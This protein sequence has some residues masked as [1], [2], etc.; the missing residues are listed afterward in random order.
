MSIQNYLN[1]IKSAVFGKDVRQ[2]I[3]DAIKQCYDDASIDHDNANMEVKLARGSHDT[4]NERFTSVEENI[5][6]NSEQL[7]KNVYEMQTNRNSI[8]QLSTKVDSVVSGSPKGVYDTVEALK[9]SFPTGSQGIYLVNNDG[10]WYYWNENDWI[11][12]G[13]YQSTEIADKSI[14][15][16]KLIYNYVEGLKSKNLFDKRKV[17]LG[18]YISWGSGN[19]NSNADYFLS[20]FIPVIP[21]KTYTIQQKEIIAFFNADKSY[22]SGIDGSINYRKNYTFTVPSGVY[23][24]RIST[25][26]SL[27]DLVQLEIGDTATSYESYN[28]KVNTELIKDGD[29]GKKK[30]DF[31][32][33][34]GVK[35]KNLFNKN[36]VTKGSYVSQ[37]NGELGINS[38]YSA[39]DYIEVEELIDYCIKYGEQLAFY[40]SLKRYLSG[41]KPSDGEKIT[42]PANACYVRI[43]TLNS[44]LDNQQFEKGSVSTEYED[45]YSDGF[46][47]EGKYFKRNSIPV[48]ALENFDIITD[49]TRLYTLNDAW[50]AWLNGEKFPVAFFG[51]STTEGLRTTGNVTNVV[52]TD[53]ISPNAY[54]KVLEDM[55][56]KETGNNNLRIYNA[57]FSGQTIDFAFENLEAEFGDGTPY[58][59][60][61]MVG[62]SF[63]INDRGWYKNNPKGFRDNFKAKLL[64]II[65]YFKSKNIQPF[66]LTTQ[67]YAHMITPYTNY[68]KTSTCLVETIANEVKREIVVEYNLELI[69]VNEFTEKLLIYSKHRA[70]ELL[71]DSTHFGDLGH[72]Y[73]A[74]LFFKELCPKV[75]IVTEPCILGLLNQ[76]AYYLREDDMSWSSDKFKLIYNTT[77]TDTTDIKIYDLYIFNDSKRQFKVKSYINAVGD[78]YVKINDVKYTLSEAE[79]ELIEI[80]LGLHHLEV[81]T[82]L[83]NAIDFKGFELY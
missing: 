36:T 21:K 40:D 56:K 12:G 46:Y 13:V 47:F 68:P 44:N 53:N 50:V 18:K 33:M 37:N 55:L 2:S 5:K 51:D 45:F 66:L 19:I 35:A 17:E 76:K 39:S 30:L 73:E 70:N 63:G 32:P 10:C 80:D 52:G 34:E 72:K 83:S 31:I 7:D 20:D 62:I 22:V 8:V 28:V 27:L 41:A 6:N 4:L 3:H 69:E 14:S 60:V 64:S 65:A 42:I 9:A 54:S 23:Y 57:G 29:I 74:G 61:K 1:Q 67:A 16:E 43:T 79:K 81:Y 26:I 48:S 15:D 77:K 78:V 58:N 71:A 11:K 82:G 24:M 38:A 59:D 25:A 75:D 49:K